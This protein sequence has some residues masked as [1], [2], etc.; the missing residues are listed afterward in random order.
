METEIKIAMYKDKIKFL[1]LFF[2]YLHLYLYLILFFLVFLYFIYNS[3]Q[4][5]CVRVVQRPGC[6]HGEELPYFF[7]A[8]LVGGL[9]H[10]PKNYTRSEIALSESMILYLTNFARTG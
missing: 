9:S 1:L 5:L 8:P 4:L 3:N 2:F 6:I 10:W 7:G